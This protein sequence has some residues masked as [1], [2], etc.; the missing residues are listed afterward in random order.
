M[1]STIIIDS[2]IHSRANEN[3]LKLMKNSI[4][5][6]SKKKQKTKKNEQYN[7]HQNVKL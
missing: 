5:N 4:K 7:H 3:Y 1:K 6:A 2:S